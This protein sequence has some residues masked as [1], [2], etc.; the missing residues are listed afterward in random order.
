[1]P[2]IVPTPPTAEEVALAQRLECFEPAVRVAVIRSFNH[3][4][5]ALA[6]AGEPVP[7]PTAQNPSPE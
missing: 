7:P 1:M 3:L 5:D 2:I 4:L 6:V